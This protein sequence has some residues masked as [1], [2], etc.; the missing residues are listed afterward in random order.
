MVEILAVLGALVPLLAALIETWNGTRPARRRAQQESAY[1][2]DLARA[3]TAISTGDA[4]VLTELF[5]TER[6]LGVR[7]RGLDPR[8]GNARERLRDTEAGVDRGS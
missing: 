1:D 4:E 6:R 5:D 7:D 3:E 8:G 2:R